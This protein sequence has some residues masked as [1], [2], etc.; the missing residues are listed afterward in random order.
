MT[1]TMPGEDEGHHSAQQ[2]A[3]VPPPGS[4]LRIWLE[5]HH[6]KQVWLAKETGYTGKHIN[7]ILTG[8]SGFSYEMAK[9]IAEATG[10]SARYWAQLLADYQ[11]YQQAG[12]V[13]DPPPDTPAAPPSEIT[14]EQAAAHK[15]ALR[16]A[17]EQGM[18]AERERQH[19]R[20]VSTANG[21]A[22]TDQHT[23][24]AIR[25]PASNDA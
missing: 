5:T 13:P 20:A 18:R 19:W 9:R 6:K 22:S 16:H 23:V 3:V 17:Y 11:M 21:V 24:E 14:R 10:T 2:P 4:V 1:T 12:I 25:E 15:Q 8:K 7:E